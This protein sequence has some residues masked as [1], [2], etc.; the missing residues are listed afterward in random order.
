MEYPD[1]VSGWVTDLLALP[2]LDPF[3][4]AGQAQRRN[5]MSRHPDGRRWIGYRAGTYLVDCA[6]RKS[7]VTDAD[8]SFIF[9]PAPTPGTVWGQ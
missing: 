1:G 8:G 9:E 4:P 7:D 6:S 5:W 3:T 2:D